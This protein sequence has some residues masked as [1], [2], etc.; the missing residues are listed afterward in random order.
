MMQV[1]ER[2]DGVATLVIMTV[3]AVDKARSERMQ[4]NQK[5]AEQKQELE[6]NLS[7]IEALSAEYTS[8]YYINLDTEEITSYSM[9]RTTANSFGET[10]KRNIKYSVAYSV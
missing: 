2:R 6:R 7:I 5:S 9:N 1:A 3:V 4:L 8:V 10:F